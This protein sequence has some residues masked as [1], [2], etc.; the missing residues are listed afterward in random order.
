MDDFWY[1]FGDIGTWVS[2]IATFLAVVV[3]VF[4][5][6][7]QDRRETEQQVHNVYAWMQKSSNGLWQIVVN[8]G[9]GA[10]IYDW[11]VM[12]KWRDGSEE[13]FDAYS[14]DDL[15]MLPPA[16]KTWPLP[17]QAS[18]VLPNNDAK[19]QMSIEFVDRTNQRWLRNEANMLV[20]AQKRRPEP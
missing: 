12:I 11:A 1:W 2:G 20:R 10:P 19:I 15:G 9:T 13:V 16:Q 14:Q 8:N 3:A 7:R 17:Q 5:S 6:H 4:Y 18:E